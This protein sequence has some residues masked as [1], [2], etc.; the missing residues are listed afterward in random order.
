[1]KAFCLWLS[2]IFPKSS[3]IFL[4]GRSR[5]TWGGNKNMEAKVMKAFCLISMFRL[6]AC[7][8][9]AAATTEIDD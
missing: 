9:D 7:V 2:N 1:M 3:N 8:D 5:F 4:K 6:K